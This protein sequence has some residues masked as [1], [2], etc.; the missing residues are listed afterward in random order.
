MCIYIYIFKDMKVLILFY[1]NYKRKQI[2]VQTM[3]FKIAFC[4][5]Q[6]V[7]NWGVKYWSANSITLYPNKFSLFVSPHAHNTPKLPCLM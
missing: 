5:I 1:K 7:V 6:A 2:P 4:S 3:C